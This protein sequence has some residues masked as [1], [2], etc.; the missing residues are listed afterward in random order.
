MPGMYRIRN[1]VYQDYYIH[2]DGSSVVAGRFDDTDRD[3]KPGE[4]SQMVCIVFFLLLG[5]L[6]DGRGDSLLFF[7]DLGSGVLRLRMT[8]RT[9]SPLQSGT[10]A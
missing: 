3:G 4:S 9:R 5:C 1:S 10:E 6:C 7:F 2:R 8:A